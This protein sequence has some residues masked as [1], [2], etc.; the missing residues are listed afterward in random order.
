[1]LSLIFGTAR[2][3]NANRCAYLKRK[4]HLCF[5]RIHKNYTFHKFLQQ[6]NNKYLKRRS[7]YT[8]INLLIYIE[9]THRIL[10]VRVIQ[11]LPSVSVCV[12]G[13]V[14]SLV[15][16]CA[17]TV[18]T[19]LM[20][21]CNQWLR[22][23]SVHIVNNCADTQFTQCS[24]LVAFIHHLFLIFIKFQNL[25]SVSAQLMTGVWTRFCLVNNCTDT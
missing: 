10:S 23:R 24:H 11:H 7:K 25:P 9:G 12:V 21:P 20:K 5:T 22:S 3:F 14:Y 1:M 2:S 4:G 16:N 6:T 15:N 17:D 19:W 18:S 13:V 8:F